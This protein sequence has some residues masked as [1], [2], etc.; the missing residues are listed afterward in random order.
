[1][2]Y[3]GT[4]VRRLLLAQ[5]PQEILSAIRCIKGRCTPQ[6]DEGELREIVKSTARYLLAW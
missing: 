3:G 4:A 1:V 6:I 5:T 2:P